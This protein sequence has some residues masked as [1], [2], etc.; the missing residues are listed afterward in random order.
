MDLVAAIVVSALAFGLTSR[1][2][3]HD[4]S[5]RLLVWLL[6]IAMFLASLLY[7]PVLLTLQWIR[8]RR[9]GL[10]PGEVLWIVQAGA[11]WIFQAMGLV[12]T[13]GSWFVSDASFLIYLFAVVLPAQIF[14]FILAASGFVFWRTIRPRG[15][16]PFWTE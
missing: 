16:V 14:V 4:L 8:G 6:G 11:W 15:R 9:A 1:L 3:P 13:R 12:S 5:S 10:G 7:G 2:V